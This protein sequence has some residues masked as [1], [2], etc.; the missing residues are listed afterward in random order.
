MPL[1]QNFELALSKAMR[2]CAYQER[3]VKEVKQKL[4][5]I[6]VSNTDSDKILEIL[7]EDNYLNQK[8]FALSFVSGKF[9]I[10][11]WGKNKIKNELFKKDIE[12][13]IIELAIS[14]IDIKEY[15]KCM[16]QLFQEKLKTIKGENDFIKKNK[17]AN[18]LLSK[19]YESELIY[20]LL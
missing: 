11:K 12:K 20:D 6:N 7:I 2:F 1:E 4:K 15:K 17:V 18:Y 8:R 5:K 9:R 13:E 10:K 19:G 14:E 3:C 16:Q